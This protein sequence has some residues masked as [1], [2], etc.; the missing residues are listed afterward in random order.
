MYARANTPN[1]IAGI[2]DKGVS[3]RGDG[4]PARISPGNDITTP[5]R[6]VVC[7]GRSVGVG[8]ENYRGENREGTRDDEGAASVVVASA[9]VRTAAATFFI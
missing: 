5:R 8:R 9:R 6:P 3:A 4:R 1:E 2:R 7:R